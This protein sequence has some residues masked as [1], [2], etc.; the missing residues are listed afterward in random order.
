MKI[1]IMSFAHTHAAGYIHL[2][3]A[4]PGIELKGADP[5]PH[6]Q[7]EVRGR[8]LADTLGVAYVADYDEL[9]AWGPDAVIVTSENRRHR[10]HV[11]MAAE[12]G[13][14]ILCEKPLATTWEDGLAMRE[15]VARHGVRLMM[16]FPVRF[17][18]TFTR[19]RREY[20]AGLLGTVFAIRG[21]NNGTL[22]TTRT[23]FTEPAL[24]GGGALVDHVVHIADLIDALL[25][26]APQRVTATTNRILHSHRARAETAGL[27]TIEYA[28]GTIAAVDC[29][30]SEA[31]TSPVWGDVRMSVAGTSGTVD[32]DFFGPAVR[33]LD[34]STGKPAVR[35]YGQDF[36]KT[37]L[38]SFLDSVRTGSPMEPS[39][40]VGLRTLSIVVAAQESARTGRTVEVHS[41]WD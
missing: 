26:V 32:I 4:T 27:V 16:A 23:W 21:A 41:L 1:A 36:D 7:G 24:S 29:S 13:A 30:W 10:E 12:T 22:P 3:Q 20:E 19:L 14:D 5:G 28:D 9:L 11:E 38:T 40:D 33:G 2:L 6:P 25:G 18:S 17:A 37:M 34:S 39:I 31:D 8:R 15:A 35:R